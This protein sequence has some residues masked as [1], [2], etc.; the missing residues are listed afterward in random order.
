MI[1]RTLVKPFSPDFKWQNQM[2]DQKKMQKKK[3]KI[4]GL[5]KQNMYTKQMQADKTSTKK[6]VIIKTNIIQWCG[7]NEISAEGAF[8][9]VEKIMDVTKV[10]PPERRA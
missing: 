7:W 1:K 10:S 4:R 3:T 5:I 2:D 8:D 9:N 6:K